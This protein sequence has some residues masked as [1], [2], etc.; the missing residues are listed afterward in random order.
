MEALKLADYAQIAEVVAAVAVVVS[1][2]YVGSELQSNTAA[3]RAASL[4]AVSS[5]SAQGVQTL[6]SDSA[7]SRIRRL[8]DADL[9]VLAEDEAYRYFLWYRG[10]GLT[11]QNVYLQNELGVF[12]SRVWDGYDNIICNAMALPG[13]KGGW[14]NHRS[15]LDPG[16]VAVA[17]G[18]P[19]F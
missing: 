19:T 12:E 7:L 17:E 11:M 8:G 5:F 3:V 10:F 18:C 2:V 14:P 1:L 15:V 13:V 9:S 16:F 6:A 4:Q